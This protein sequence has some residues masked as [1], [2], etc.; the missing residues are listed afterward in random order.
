MPQ[1]EALRQTQFLQLSKLGKP[2]HR[3]AKD[4]LIMSTNCCS[5]L[6][7]TLLFPACT[8]PHHGF[9]RPNS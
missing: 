7:A 3:V 8:A 6:W 1:F 9:A 2:R 5:A 4:L